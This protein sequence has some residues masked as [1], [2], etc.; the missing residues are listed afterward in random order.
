MPRLPAL[1]SLIL[2]LALGA[3]AVAGFA[4]WGWFPLPILALAVLY[5]LA[6]TEAVR[7]AAFKGFAFGLGYF[8]GGVSWVYVSLHDF[9]MMPLPLAVLATALFCAFLAL[10]PAAALALTA[11]LGGLRTWRALTVAP[12]LWLLNE[13]LRGWLFTGF[14]WLALGYSQVP[15]SPLAGYAPIIGTYG[16]S[17]LVALTAAA[18]ALRRG[19]PLLLAAGLWLGGWGLQQIDWT[20]P[21]GAPVTVS[22][23]Q[24]NVAQEM[25]FRPERA[26]QTLQDYLRLSQSSNAKLIVLPETALPMFLDDAPPAYLEL[27]HWHARSMGG[28]L[29]L[30]VPERLADG[31]Y[32]NSVISLGVSPRQTYRKQHLVP[33]GEFVPW[34]FGW[35]V[36]YLHIPLSDFSRGD[37]VQPPLAVAGQQVAVNICYEDA[38]GEEVIRA[39]PAASLLVNVSNDAWFGDSFSPWQHLQLAQMRALETGRPMLRANNTGITAIIDAKGRVSAQL[40][41]FVQGVLHGRTQ[42]HQGLTPYARFGNGPALLL[43]VLGLLT[44]K[45]RPRGRQ[46]FN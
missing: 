31:R 11:R 21:V 2:P 29:L 5:H 23:V 40:Q 34:G 42:G 19:W 38:F 43:A 13:W 10:F 15:L 45:L 4:P 8:G 33:F 9:G 28:D 7:A 22:L 30:G 36:D 17:G 20:R 14:P 12:A 25:K 24:G 27:L 3:L 44:A 35:V 6:R 37:K 1:N 32:F 41:P 18:L 39:L 26:V 46:L 16:V